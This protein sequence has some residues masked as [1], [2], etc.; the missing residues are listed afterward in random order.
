M[1]APQQRTLYDE[2]EKYSSDPESG[3]GAPP[4]DIAEGDGE[5]KRN[6]KPRHMQMI[7]IGGSI[8]AGLFVGAG[9]ALNSGGPGSLVIDFI[10]IGF[11][12]LLTVNALGEL[13]GKCFCQ[14]K[15]SAHSDVC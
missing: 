2:K 6:L 11:M 5:L 8:G 7:A 10:I 15:G 3:V 13:A 1:S 14:Y 9:S 12:L 4:H